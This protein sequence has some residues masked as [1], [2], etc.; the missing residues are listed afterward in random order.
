M[1]AG[2]TTAEGAATASLSEAL[3][4]F[5][6]ATRRA[7]GRAASQPASDGISL[8]QFHVLEPL[9]DGPRTNRQLAES[10]GITSPTATRMIDGLVTR[11]VVTRVEDPTDR[12]A[13]LISLTDAGREALTA[14]LGEYRRVREQIAGTLEPEERLAAAE[15]LNR[16][17]LVIEEL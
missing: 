8:A 1:A 12:R 13:V 6:R 3:A 15:L 2:Q 11:G 7:R 16:L 17:A 9:A 4:E 14:K 10:A 5:F